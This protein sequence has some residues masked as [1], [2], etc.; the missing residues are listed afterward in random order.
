MLDRHQA[1]SR[2]LVI[3]GIGREVVRRPRLLVA[4]LLA[5][6]LV[7]LHMRNG[8][9]ALLAETVAPADR[10]AAAQ[11][12]DDVPRQRLRHFARAAIRQNRNPDAQRRHQGH[13]RAPPGPTAAVPNQPITAIAVAS[14]T[15]AVVGFAEFGESRLRAVDARCM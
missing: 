6:V 11:P 5:R 7:N 9:F 8:G 15:E 12:I 2:M 10:L 13:A 3:A 14:E 1:V 4:S